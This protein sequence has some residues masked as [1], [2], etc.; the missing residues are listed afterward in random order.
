MYNLATYLAKGGKFEVSFLVGDFGQ[1]QKEL[2]ENVCVWKAIPIEGKK[3]RYI[4]KFFYLIKFFW[5]IRKISAD[6]YIQRAAGMET[7]LIAFVCKLL[8]KKF[9][10]MT[11]SDIDVDGRYE[12]QH[13]IGGIFYR[14]GL[15]SADIVV[16]Q[17]EE[18]KEI[19]KERYRVFAEVIKN[20][21]IFPKKIADISSKKFVLWVGTSQ[22]LKQPKVFLKMTKDMPEEKFVMVMP[23]HNITLW[24]KI[25]DE[26]ASIPNIEFIEKVP[27]R[28]IGKY[29]AEAKLFVNTSTFEGFPNT[30][31]QATMHAAP[32][33]SLNVD[34]DNFLE[35]Y[36]CGFCSKGDEEKL[37]EL[38]VVLLGDN[39]RWKKMCLNARKYAGE[40]HNIEINIKKILKILG[41]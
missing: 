9:I 23:K 6:V 32:I 39:E 17:N 14:Y 20:S 29:F 8:G 13:K 5:I 41:H 37:V 31:V 33:A 16:T 27:F 12:K 2:F 1:K 24:N 35:N 18:H 19:L 10:Y 40:N 30:F 11:A 36:N 3:I 25:K 21:F 34:P 26:A 7:G 15:K 28:E 38:S 22:P 4:A